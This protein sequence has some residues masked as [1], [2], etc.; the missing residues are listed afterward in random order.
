MSVL[1]CR[2]ERAKGNMLEA[3]PMFIALA[4][5]AVAKGRDTSEVRDAAL[6]FLVARVIYVPAYVSGIPMLRSLIWL[7]GMGSLLV[8]ALL[9]I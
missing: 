4:V 2:L 8:M 3:L 9:M 7:V 1:A 5:L 6:V